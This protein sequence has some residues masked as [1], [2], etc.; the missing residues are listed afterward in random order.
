MFA[1]PVC[2]YAVSSTM[3]VFLEHVSD[4]LE[5][6]DLLE[7]GRGLRG[8]CGFIVCRSISEEIAPRS[9]EHFATPSLTLGQASA[10]FCMPI[11][12]TDMFRRNISDT[13]LPTDSRLVSCSTP[14]VL[15]PA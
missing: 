10:Q 7:K 15:V 11:A 14:D 1:A 3:K 12:Q 8:K 9:Y 13:L 6:P 5:F 2:G 4:C